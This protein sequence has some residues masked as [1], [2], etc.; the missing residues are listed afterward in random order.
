M[1]PPLF[2]PSEN[3]EPGRKMPFMSGHELTTE[4]EIVIRD[5]IDFESVA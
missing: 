3:T 2:Q 1:A 4:V 5:K